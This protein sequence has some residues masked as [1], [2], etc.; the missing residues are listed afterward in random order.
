MVFD[1]CLY[2]RYR[3]SRFVLWISIKKEDY[4]K[5]YA[6]AHT[7]HEG[8][9]KMSYDTDAGSERDD[10]KADIQRMKTI[11]KHYR[12]QHLQLSSLKHV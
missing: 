3:D 11:S 7:R 1:T 9:Y 2:L 8:R 4:A 10:A 5:I 6:E 12:G